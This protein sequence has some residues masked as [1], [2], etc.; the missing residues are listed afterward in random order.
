MPD[1]SS[2]ESQLAVAGGVSGGGP[3]PTDV[4]LNFD[5]LLV[6]LGAPGRA[7]SHLDRLRD[8]AWPP[9]QLD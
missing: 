8:T 3:F 5:A 1:G 6:A 2:A 7:E 4:G 9:G